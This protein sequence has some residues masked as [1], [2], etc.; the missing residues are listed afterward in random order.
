MKKLEV[1]LVNLSLGPIEKKSNKNLI[2]EKDKRI[3]ILQKKLKGATSDH[4]QTKEIMIIQSENDELKKEVMELKEKILQINRE[5][6]DL[7]REINELVS[8]RTVEE[9]L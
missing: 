6:E 8:Q 3:E 1:D 4:P 7:A 9:P 5:K 2:K